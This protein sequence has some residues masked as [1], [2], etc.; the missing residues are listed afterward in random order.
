M[1]S[2]RAVVVI[3]IVDVPA[4]TVML[5]AFS[6]LFEPDTALTVNDDV[7]AAVGVPVIAPVEEFSDSPCGRLPAE[8]DHV[9]LEALAESTAL[10][11]VFT[12]PE[13]RLVVVIVIEDVPCA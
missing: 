5:S 12:V 11:E 6:A 2:G 7:P 10:Y 3:V 4:F 9:T 1:P 8:T 13:G